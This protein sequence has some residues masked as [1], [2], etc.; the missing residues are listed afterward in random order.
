MRNFGSGRL[1]ATLWLEQGE[2][3]WRGDGQN[4]VFIKRGRFRK[5][6]EAS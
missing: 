4:E 3:F 1:W 2:V 6:A 5:R